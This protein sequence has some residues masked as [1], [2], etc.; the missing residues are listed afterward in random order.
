MDSIFD[1]K[2][3]WDW[4]T[5]IISGGLGIAALFFGPLVWAAVGV[6]LLRSLSGFF[7]DREEKARKQR[8]K[9]ESQLKRDVSKIERNLRKE[10]D[11]WFHQDLLKKQV[12]VFIY[13]LQMVISSTLELADRQ[14]DLAWRINKQQKELHRTLLNKTLEQ[15]GHRNSGGLILDIARVPGQAV[16]FLI[17]PKTTFPEDMRKGL[18]KLL[19]EEVWFLANTRNKTSILAQ[20]IGHDCDRSSIRIE[21]KI[22]AAHVSIGQLNAIGIS[23]IRL[24]QQLTEIQIFKKNENTLRKAKSSVLRSQ[25]ARGPINQNAADSQRREKREYASVESA[26][27]YKETWENKGYKVTRR[28][29]ILYL[30]HGH[31]DAADSQRREKREY[32]SVESAIRWKRTW[33]AKGYTVTRRGNVLYLKKGKMYQ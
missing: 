27:R 3:A 5:T 19:G 30:K 11:A 18:E 33:E 17:D 7:E 2:R 10:L 16:M 32:M 25:N 24:A 31:Q 9:L 20:A 23:R 21:S 14:R 28:G 26:I 22:Q 8:N 4:G 1:A 13:E 15:L 6:G 12:N 29:N